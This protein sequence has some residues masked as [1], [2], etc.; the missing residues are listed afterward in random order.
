MESARSIEYDLRVSR[1]T[2]LITGGAGYIGSHVADAF[3]NDG[4]NVIIYD[5]LYRG[6]ESRIEYLKWKHHKEVPFVKADIRDAEA[7][8]GALGRFKPDGIIHTAALKSVAESV[9]KPD[10]Y[11]EINFLATKKLLEIISSLGVNNCIFSSTAA[12][13]GAP[14]HSKPIKESELKNPISPY[15]ASKLAAENAVDEFLQREGNL[16]TSLRFFNVIGTQSIE[17]SDNSIDNLVPIVI[18]KLNRDEAPVIFGI[19]HPTPDGTCIRDYVDVRDVALAHLAA[20]NSTLRLPLALNVGT[21]RGTSVREMINQIYKAANQG[22]VKVIEGEP[23]T[24]DCP[25]LFADSS[26][27]RHQLGVTCER[28]LEESLKSLF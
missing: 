23:R 22:P 19:N 12:V 17:L 20:A 10:E 26:K 16:G 7:L 21:G 14:D 8:K 24:G 25:I 1:E 9:Q 4:K 18:D 5:S 6:L 2:W 11:F 15:G 3:L 28:T 27:L 13:Y